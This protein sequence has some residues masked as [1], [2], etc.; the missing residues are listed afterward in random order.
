VNQQEY[1]KQIDEVIA[2]GTFKDT[3]ESLTQYQ[4]PYWYKQMK[5]GIFIHWGVFSVPAYGHEWYARNMYE[6]GHDLF[7][8]H[9]ATYGAHTK[10]GYKD[11][12]PMLKMEKFDPTEWA[13]LFKQSGA[14][15]VLPVAEHHDGFCMYDSDFSEWTA[16]KM[17]PHRNVLGD[18]S[19]EI[20]KAGLVFGTSSHR[21]EHWWFLGLGKNFDSDIK[22]VP[23][24]DLYWPSVNKMD[25]DKMKDILYC[26]PSEEFLEDW[27]VRTCELIDRYRPSILYF[28]W[29]IQQIAFKPYLKKM[30]AYYYN[31]GNEWGVPVVINYKYDAFMQGA[32]VSDVE[33]GQISSIQP[34]FWQMDTSVSKNSW[35][36]T[37][38]N[39]YKKSEDLV[40]SLIDI[41]SKNGTLLLN[42]GP[43]S[44]GTIPEHDAHILIEI[45]KWMT[46]NGEGIYETTT[47]KIFGEGSTQVAEGFFAEQDIDYCSQDIRF[48]L[49]KNVLYAFVL[50]W[51]KDGVVKIKTLAEGSKYFNGVIKEIAILGFDE[52]PQWTRWDEAMTVK[53]LDVSSNYPICIKI[54]MD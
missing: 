26:T 10:F 53:A 15:Y 42:V 30:A 54:T 31:R 43:K 3:W 35:C 23:Y 47:W 39:Q 21:A 19:A 8:H 44:D 46:V 48:T 27:L 9:T 37:E 6:Q 24:G 40:C 18:L 1:L 20:K 33:R 51:P 45:G 17:G 28:D 4:V 52:K 7:N 34:N 2:E 11:F 36:Y 50:K 14:R 22:E 16:A 12:I 41:V 25:T 49:K 32:A 13:A 29:W 38:G 5:F